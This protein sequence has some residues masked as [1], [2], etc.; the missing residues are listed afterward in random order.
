MVER[1]CS[2]Q[3]PSGSPNP[4]NKGFERA[5]ERDREPNRLQREEC[6]IFG[7][8][9]CQWSCMYMFMCVDRQVWYTT[10][11]TDERG[12]LGFLNVVQGCVRRRHMR[13]CVMPHHWPTHQHNTVH[14]TPRGARGFRGDINV[15]GRARPS[16]QH[17]KNFFFF[18]CRVGGGAIFRKNRAT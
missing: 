13:A 8:F 3:S 12:I 10:D 14:T 7:N 9:G 11:A 1:A 16:T 17:M 4:Q 18:L 15:N 2:L 5:R 6:R